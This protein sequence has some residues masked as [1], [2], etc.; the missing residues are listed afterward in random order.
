MGLG[1]VLRVTYGATSLVLVESIV[2]GLSAMPG[3]FTF[4]FILDTFSGVFGG[5]FE[6]ALLGIAFVPAYLVFAMALMFFTPMATTLLRWR[7]VPGR[8]RVAD[9][10]WGLIRWGQYNAAIHLVHLF[11]GGVLRST[12]LWT[13]FLRLNGAQIGRDVHINTLNV[14]DHNQLEIGDH[15]VVGSDVKMSGHVGER[16]EILIAPIRLG[17]RVTIGTNTIVY[18][19]VTVG[20]G[21]AVGAMSLVLKGATL[22]PDCVYAGVP[23]QRIRGPDKDRIA[24][25]AV[26]DLGAPDDDPASPDVDY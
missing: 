4:R 24:A 20:A 16:G 10:E 1:K 22:E 12:P 5:Y 17:E 18:P 25:T 14:Y 23:V 11:A 9:F 2:F 13:A 3:L 7:S 21:T 26:P 15:S 6:T 8:Y 19:G